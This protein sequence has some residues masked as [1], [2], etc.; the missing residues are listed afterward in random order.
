VSLLA[1][2]VVMASLLA[3]RARNPRWRV[4]TGAVGFNLALQGATG[5]C[6]ASAVMY[7]AGVPLARDCA[8]R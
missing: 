6:P 2:S 4:L 7:K 3:A 8:R 1:G 5:W